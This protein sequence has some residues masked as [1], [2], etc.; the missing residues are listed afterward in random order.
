MKKFKEYRYIGIN[1]IITSRVKLDGVKHIPLFHIEAEPG[2]I[3]TDG[4]VKTYA[5]SIEVDELERWYEIV[6]N[7]K[8]DN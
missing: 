2:F 6:D 8:K 3:L 4:E 7:T 1:G 5:I